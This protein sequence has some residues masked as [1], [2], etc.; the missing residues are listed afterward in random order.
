LKK[1]EINFI[2]SVKE[3]KA[4]SDGELESDDEAE[5]VTSSG[6]NALTSLM[7]SYQSSDSEQ[8]TPRKITSMRCLRRELNMFKIFL[9]VLAGTEKPDVKKEEETKEKQKRNRK[10]RPN[11]RKGKDSQHPSAP[12]AKQFIRPKRLTLLQKVL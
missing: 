5:P 11:K 10:K 12:A 4:L 6:S 1:I 3:V 7:G 2:F 9:A 8:D